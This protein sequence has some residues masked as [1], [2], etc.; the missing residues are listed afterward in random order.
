MLDFIVGSKCSYYS[1]LQPNIWHVERLHRHVGA[2]ALAATTSGVNASKAW[3]SRGRLRPSAWYGS[4]L[5]KHMNSPNPPCAGHFCKPKRTSIY[6]TQSV[7]VHVCVGSFLSP[8]SIGAT[9]MGNLNTLSLCVCVRLR[10]AWRRI[11]D[12]I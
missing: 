6:I 7:S 4:V 2:L 5:D 8:D 10:V 9:V 3:Y 1:I 12:T 11:W